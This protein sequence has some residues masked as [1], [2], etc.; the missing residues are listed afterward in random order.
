VLSSRWDQL[1]SDHG[2][3]ALQYQTILRTSLI[4][5]ELPGKPETPLLIELVQGTEFALIPND[6]EPDLPVR[7]Y[8]GDV[9]AFAET[10]SGFSP[11]NSQTSSFAHAIALRPGEYRIVVRAIYEIRMFGDPCFG[12]P[13]II[14]LRFR[15][16]VDDKQVEVVEGSGVVQD[17]VDGWFMG[18]WMSVGVR[19]SAVSKSPAVLMI[20]EDGLKRDGIRME[21]FEGL[22]IAPGQLRPVAVKITQTQPVERDIRVLP[23]HLR[24]SVD[25][26]QRVLRWD[27]PLHHL[28]LSEKL[29]P[30]KMTFPSPFS[31]SSGIPA[32]VSYAMVVPPPSP[33]AR[34]SNP[35]P[36]ILATHGAG[37]DACSPF[38][39]SAIPHRPGGWAV[40]PTGKN[41]WGEDWHGGS[42]ADAWAA[43]GALPWVARRLGCEVSDETL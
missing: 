42:M 23:L 33:T 20:A 18:E 43:R 1:R 40:L 37:V 27:I 24:V 38:W 19:V 29:P 35:P 11:R 13:P 25:G 7:W 9:Y 4:V 16:E 30:F 3:A 21:T 34:L 2:W 6:R 15:A 22:G 41:E 8:A 10:P 17:L 31:P 28:F 36:V 26:E 32:L 39:S 12:K 5:P 14:R